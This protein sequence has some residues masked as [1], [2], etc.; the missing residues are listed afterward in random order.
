MLTGWRERAHGRRPS[1]APESATAPV[2]A[3]QGEPGHALYLHEDEEALLD[4][5]VRFV[6]E[7][8]YHGQ[9]TLVLT[10]GE[11]LAA[12]DARLSQHQLAGWVAGHDAAACLERVSIAGSPD[13]ERFRATMSDLLAGEEPGSA[14]VYGELG[15]LLAARG[16]LAE[17]LQLEHLW[18]E[19]AAEQPVLRL[20]AYPRDQL[21]Q[22]GQHDPVYRAH[23]HVRL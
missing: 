12:L 11:R 2:S 3:M 21:G 14:Q 10:S 16:G 22:H 20:C 18:N 15:A 5:L 23:S 19:L 8:H 6:A 4:V 7:G 17:A 1:P 9:R 13:R